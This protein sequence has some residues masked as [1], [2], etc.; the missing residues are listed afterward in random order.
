MELLEKLYKTYS[1]T[2][3][4]KE[5][6][7]FIVR[8]IKENCRNTMIAKDKKGNLYITKGKANTYPC[9]AAHMDQVQ[10]IHSADFGVYRSEDILFG[11]SKKNKRYEGLGADDKNGIWVALKCLQKFDVLKVTFFV[12]EE[13][14]CTGS[15]N[16]VISFFNDCRFV[17]EMEVIL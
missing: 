7:K 6:R 4:E 10:K 14:G 12:E 16:A 17:L 11:Y 9:L 1:P 3:H 15:E 8:W 2:G 5:M 13:S